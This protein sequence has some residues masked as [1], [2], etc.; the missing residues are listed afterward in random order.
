MQNKYNN[1]NMK[2]EQ[3]KQHTLDYIKIN[4]NLRSIKS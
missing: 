3:K 2:I 1:K 4:N